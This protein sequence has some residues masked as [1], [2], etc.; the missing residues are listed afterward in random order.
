M[1][2]NRQITRK[3]TK[4]DRLKSRNLAA[5][6]DLDWIVK[7][8]ATKLQYSEFD[9]LLDDQESWHGPDESKESQRGYQ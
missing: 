6:I 1:Q 9:S 5:H 2:Y 7:R 4:F 8:K 3:S